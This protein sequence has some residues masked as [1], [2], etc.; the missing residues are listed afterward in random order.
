MTRFTDSPFEYMMTQKPQAGR[1]SNAEPPPL[2]PDH[3]ADDL[4]SC[5]GCG[6]GNG[7]PCVG[8]CMK[9]IQ[10]SRCKPVEKGEKQLD[11]NK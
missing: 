5:Y 3:L 11:K 6:Y 10:N 8:F 7:R 4:R 9:E 2:P 1:L